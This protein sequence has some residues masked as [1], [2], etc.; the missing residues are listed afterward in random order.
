M[1]VTDCIS[2]TGNIIERVMQVLWPYT[3]VGME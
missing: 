2:D 1:G 3:A